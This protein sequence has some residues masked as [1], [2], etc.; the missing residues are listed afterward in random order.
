MNDQIPDGDE[1]S[2]PHDFEEGLLADSEIL[3]EHLRK[4]LAVRNSFYD[5]LATLSAGSIAVCI[6]VGLALSSKGRPPQISHGLVYLV[7]A[8]WVALLTSVGHN[9]LLV[10]SARLDARYQQDELVKKIVLRST[11]YPWNY[12][13]DML[14]QLEKVGQK[15]IEPISETQKKR[16]VR[17]TYCE[18]AAEVLG[19]VSVLCFLSGYTIA[20]F[21]VIGLWW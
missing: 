2:I 5:K 3:Q 4:N 7:G 20:L 18:G 12:S 10:W 21:G 13:A 6:S 11:R 14:K 19:I 1:D 16:L 17:K 8:F 15:A 9:A